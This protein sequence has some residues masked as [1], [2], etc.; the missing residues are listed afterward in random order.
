M[1]GRGARSHPEPSASPLAQL[2]D[3]LSSRGHFVEDSPG[4]LQ[5]MFARLRQHHLLAQSV[6]KPTAHIRLQRLHRVADRR[7]RQ[8]K[9]PGGQRETARAGKDA[10]GGELSTVEGRSHA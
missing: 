6:Q 8:K 9:L 7:L 3:F 1:A 2:L 10:E 5:Q 4:V